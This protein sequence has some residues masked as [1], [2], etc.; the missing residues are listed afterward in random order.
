MR[1]SSWTGHTSLYG[2]D[3]GLLAASKLVDALATLHAR[4]AAGSPNANP[5]ADAASTVATL[6]PA[7]CRHLLGVS[8]RSD[9]PPHIAL[10][11][12]AEEAGGS[13]IATLT[14]LSSAPM[15][16]DA[17][18]GL[19][20]VVPERFEAGGRHGL[21]LTFGVSPGVTADNQPTLEAIFAAASGEEAVIEAE[22]S[23]Q[24]MRQLIEQQRA[25]FDNNPS[26]LI[27]TA[28]GLIKQ[29]NRGFTDILRGSE[30][31]LLNQPTQLMFGNAENYAAFGAVVG[32]QLARGQ[33]VSL[34]W[35]L[36]RLDGE[37]FAGMVSGR[38]VSTQGHS[39]AAIWVIE[40][41]SERKRLQTQVAEQLAFQQVL[42]DTIPVAILYKDAEG[43]YLGINKTYRET[44]ANVGD[45]M[46]G[47]TVLELAALTPA[48]RET[49][50]Q[51]D[52]RI[53]NEGATVR[54]VM[55]R[56]H[57]DGKIH[58]TVRWSR[59]FRKP[60]GS[61]GGLIATFVDISDQKRAQEALQLA[62]EAADAAS[63]AKSDFL[64]NMS[65][66]IRTPMNAI[67]GMTGLVLD[68]PLTEEQ[69]DYLDTVRTASESLL[70]IIDEV[71]D[72]SKIEAGYMTL[73]RIDFGL[74]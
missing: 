6:L 41:I 8:S 25:I 46:L 20:D 5:D 51:E 31:L 23:A 57:L 58:Q 64:A 24:A 56:R 12:D 48:Q 63:Q 17:G 21:R 10:R 67:I 7:L 61:P 13:A 39:R 15:P 50:H 53:I 73:E 65:H 11:C 9:P 19:V 36:H 32:P 34:E 18:L 42:M 1:S 30:E 43:R 60:D 35:P 69:H 72:F 37:V 74:R 44:L 26:G 33:P 66:E 49:Q 71:L 14:F 28:D 54:A 55:P 16:P 40:D 62:K 68:T 52:L 27:F 3:S 47:K 22:R 2:P 45:D 29:L 70:T 4:P 59:G 38:G